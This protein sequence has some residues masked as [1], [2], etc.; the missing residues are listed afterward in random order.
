MFNCLDVSQSFEEKDFTNFTGY[1]KMEWENYSAVINAAR[2][3]GEFVVNWF[4]GSNRPFYLHAQTLDLIQINER[5]RSKFYN[6]H[7]YASIKYR[8]TACRKTLWNFEA[9]Y[10]REP[11]CPSPEPYVSVFFLDNSSETSD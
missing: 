7:Y 8:E 4:N 5:E 2:V 10:N 3:D 6:N 1:I 11:E 9:F